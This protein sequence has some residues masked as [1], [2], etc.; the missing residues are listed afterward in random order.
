MIRPFSPA[1]YPALVALNN[2]TY[3]DYKETEQET[4]FGDEHRDAKLKWGRLVFETE[5][6]IMGVANWG[7]SEGMYHPQKFH[8]HV[9]THP[10]YRKRGIATAL[11]NALLE[12]TAP[13]DPVAFRTG[14]RED[15]SDSVTF[16]AKRGFV[17]EMRHFESHLNV[18]DFDFGAFAGDV[19]KAESHGITVK[20]HTE[21]ANEPEY[22]NRLHELTNTVAADV[23]SPEA[24]T[25]I[26]K[27]QFRKYLEM[28]NF[29]PDATFVAIDASG[30]YVGFSNLFA[31]LSEPEFL[32]TG[33][34]G[35]RRENR[36]QGVAMALKLRAVEYARSVGATRI[37]TT[38][39]TNNAGMLS[40][41]ER[42]GF[43]KQPAWLNLVCH[44][45]PESPST[46]TPAP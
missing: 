9:S 2:A 15:W 26:D 20:T 36:R 44:L 14:V 39:E 43:V 25:D 21:L 5:G 40:I 30:K 32:N 28:P 17:E 19:A 3:P 45:Q 35:V 41:N 13:L 4:R 23:P 27:A 11:Y 31:N 7:N 10:D 37:R 8:T 1:D 33:L 6:Q 38:N 18:Q 34:T 42:L 24:H 46:T 12:A 29:L 22:M 16:A